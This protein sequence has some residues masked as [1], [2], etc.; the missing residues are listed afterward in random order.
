VTRSTAR[1][2]LIIVIDQLRADVLA[3]ALEDAVALPNMSRLA[4]GGVRFENHHTVTVPCGPSRVSFLTGQHAMSH[5]AV[6]NGS[7][8]LDHIPN[9]ATALREVGRE[10]LLFGYTDVQP[11]PT[12]LAP[13]D[14]AR[15]SYTQPI[16][17]IT[18]VQEM[19][20]E[21]WAWLA[22]LRRKGY[23]VPDAGAADFER[24]YRPEGGI[25]GGAALYDA[26]DSDTAFLTDRTLDQL[27]VRK[28]EPWAALV[29]YI[30]PHPPFVAPAPWHDH[31]APG[32]I[33]RPA[34]L[35][36]QH[37]FFQAYHSEP[38]Q[39]GM[40]WGFDGDQ[41]ALSIEQISQ[42]RATYLGLVAEVDHH[43]GRLLDWLEASGQRD[44]TL[45]IL[46][47]D[48]GEMLGDLGL[49]GKQTPFRAASHVPL[50]MTGPQISRGAQTRLT[51]TIDVAPTIL[52]ALGA[53]V[54]ETMEGRN[55][56][57]GSDEPDAVMVEVELGH[58]TGAGRFERHWGLSSQQCRALAFERGCLRLIHFASGHVPLLFDTAVDPEC[59]TDLASARPDDVAHLTTELLDYRIAQAGLPF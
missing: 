57:Y 59:T 58:I 28:S 6:H 54:P 47:S 40:F 30:R 39:S 37:P 29:T 21:A 12:H 52:T 49:W 4:Q 38:S 3:G 8:L 32:A 5:R 15:R 16:R 42:I 14:P 11:D 35:G 31:V 7:P 27:D 26:R 19:R 44:E 20:D 50:I 43:I 45:V 13:L 34:A 18:E 41:T 2:A 1:N 25:L 55:L 53:P 48:H 23:D 51:R 9:V 22:Y 56:L 46:T 36:F 17:G 33:P 24:L 10:L